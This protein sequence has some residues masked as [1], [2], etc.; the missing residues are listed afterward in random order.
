MPRQTSSKKYDVFLSHNSKDKPAVETIALRLR[1]EYNLVIWFDKWNLTPGKPW[2]EELEEGLKRSKTVAVFLGEAGFGRWH[3]EEMRGAVSD[4]VSSQN[5]SVI[6]VLLP[7][8][9]GTL[10]LPMFLKRYTWVDLT[11][12]YDAVGVLDD[13]VN[14]IKGRPRGEKAAVSSALPPPIATEASQDRSSVDVVEL[15]SNNAAEVSIQGKRNLPRREP[16]NPQPSE[17]VLISRG[18]ISKLDNAQ[19]TLKEF[20]DGYIKFSESKIDCEKVKAKLD[21]QLVDPTEEI[22]S[23]RYWNDLTELLLHAKSKTTGDSPDYLPYMNDF[24]QYVD[25]LDAALQ[26]LEPVEAKTAKSK[27]IEIINKTY[28]HIR[29]AVMLS[30]TI[31]EECQKGTRDMLKEIRDVIE[32]IFEAEQMAA[33]LASSQSRKT[34]RALD[35]SQSPGDLGQGAALPAKVDG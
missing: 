3:N 6:P 7:G 30:Q 14:G 17:E 34:R 2:Q 1:D 12:G 31:V 25:A 4:L 23:P 18:K 8:W 20:V 10:E 26:L 11:N 21:D 29:N 33:Q 13:L 24:N 19:R 28:K 16:S 9:S 15:S 22:S 32:N 27:K 5:A 35:R